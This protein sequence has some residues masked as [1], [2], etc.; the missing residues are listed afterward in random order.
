MGGPHRHDIGKVADPR[1]PCAPPP[2]RQ[3]YQGQSPSLVGWSLLIQWSHI[4][5][6]TP[7]YFWF[8]L[9]HV[10]SACTES[11]AQRRGK[12]S[13]WPLAYSRLKELIPREILK[14]FKPQ[15]SA[16]RYR[17]AVDVIVALSN[18]KS[19]STDHIVGGVSMDLVNYR[20]KNDPNSRRLS[21]FCAAGER[22]AAISKVAFNA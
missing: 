18:K 11:R 3:G 20:L 1:S 9:I 17:I 15:H 5:A 19:W 16:A 7:V 4:R 8:L 12:W 10:A 21:I 22:N 6:H 14:S 2:A 13:T